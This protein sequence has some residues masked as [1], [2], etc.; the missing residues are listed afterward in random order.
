METTYS[1]PS[2]NTQYFNFNQAGS[3]LFASGS[4]GSSSSDTMFDSANSSLNSMHS[5]LVPKP[6]FANMARGS[7]QE[8]P[9]H[10]CG[11][12]T[13]VVDNCSKSR[14]YALAMEYYLLEEASPTPDGVRCLMSD[15]PRAFRDPKQMLWHLRECEFFSNGKYD[16]PECNTTQTFR[17][18]TQKKCSWLRTRLST[19]AMQF[20]H[21]SAAV[22]KHMIGPKSHLCVNCRHT[23]KEDLGRELRNRG[24]SPDGFEELPLY[25]SRKRFNSYPDHGKRPSTGS[26]SSSGYSSR[27]L[28]EL[29]GTSPVSELPW[30]QS[31]QLRSELEA[32]VTFNTQWGPKQSAGQS[33]AN[34]SQ[35]AETD[36]QRPATDVS[37]MSTKSMGGFSTDVSPTSSPKS[38][39]TLNGTMTMQSGDLNSLFQMS[40]QS[41]TANINQPSANLAGIV[42]NQSTH[43]ASSIGIPDLSASMFPQDPLEGNAANI[44]KRDSIRGLHYDP[45]TCDP[46]NADYTFLQFFNL[47]NTDATT[48]TP[49]EQTF[50][51]SLARSY[52]NPFPRAAA[53]PVTAAATTAQNNNYIRRH[54]TISEGISPDSADSS[55]SSPG[56]GGK[57]ASI[58][59]LRC[60][61]CDFIPTGKAEKANTYLYKHRQTH[62]KELRFSCQ[63]C[64]KTYSRKDNVTAHAKK[65]HGPFGLPGGRKRQGSGDSGDQLSVH[66]KKSRSYSNESAALPASGQWRATF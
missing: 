48:A 52:T 15:C 59:E 31:Q 58:N 39:N 66:R 29:V 61:E 41:S 56:T 60:P 1:F 42:Y 10:D 22:V 16:C 33:V 40:R 27:E 25:T 43:V 50:K 64:G 47:G 35:I 53:A 19:K 34:L 20:L 55:S 7:K 54:E 12:Q 13:R 44:A 5:N 6:S 63:Q 26:S 24:G 30:N 11:F 32:N 8:T 57:Q 21:A 28:H 45:M 23:L 51:D 37:G 3:N 38:P 62:L 2:A 4:Y 14:L 9:S 49:T 65:T 17:T 18:T 36:Y 46:D